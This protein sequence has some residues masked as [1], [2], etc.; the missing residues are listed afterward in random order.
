MHASSKPAGHRGRRGSSDQRVNAKIPRGPPSTP[1]SR[2]LRP[3][4]LSAAGE[5]PGGG[6]SV[7]GSSYL[8]RLSRF[9][10]RRT[11]VR[12]SAVVSPWRGYAPRPLHAEPWTGKRI[13]G[14]SRLLPRSLYH[15]EPEGVSYAWR[16]RSRGAMGAG[17]SWPPQYRLRSN[18]NYEQSRASEQSCAYD[19][20]CTADRSRIAEVQGRTLADA[21]FRS[22]QCVWSQ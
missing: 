15:G 19:Q 2:G 16:R 12:L 4:L 11:S 14:R 5:S 3:S 22:A 21:D 13:A 6:L 8:G 17:C 20:C 1:L 9:G 18:A 10:P 7:G